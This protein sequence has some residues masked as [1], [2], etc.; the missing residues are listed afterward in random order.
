MENHRHAKTHKKATQIHPMSNNSFIKSHKKVV[1]NSIRLRYY[2]YVLK[3]STD[4]TKGERL[5][6]RLLFFYFLY[7][8]T[9]CLGCQASSELLGTKTGYFTS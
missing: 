6:D 9:S 1:D 7:C 3:R 8:S 5:A 2:K 4:L